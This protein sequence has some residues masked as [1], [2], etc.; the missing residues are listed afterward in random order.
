MKKTLLLFLTAMLLPWLGMAQPTTENNMA[1]KMEAKTYSQY[2]SSKSADRITIPYEATGYVKKDVSIPNPNGGSY[3]NAMMNGSENYSVA[4]WI[5]TQGTINTNNH[6]NGMI[7]D[8][9]TGDHMNFNGNWYISTTNSGNLTLGGHG[10]GNYGA[11]GLLSRSIGTISMNTWNY[12]LVVVNNTEKKFEVYI[13]G[14]R[15]LS[16][17]STNGVFYPWSDGEFHFGG[18]G[19]TC[20]VDG[21]AFFNTALTQEEAERSYQNIFG[22]PEYLVSGYTFDEIADGTKGQFKN[23]VLSTIAVPDVNAWYEIYVGKNFVADGLTDWSSRTEG[24]PVLEEGRNIDRGTVHFDVPTSDMYEHVSGLTFTKIEDDD[25]DG[26][27]LEGEKELTANAKVRIDVECEEGY[28]VSSITIFDEAVTNNGTFLVVKDLD[29]TGIN[30]VVSDNFSELIIENPSEMDYTLTFADSGDPVTDKQHVPEG[31]NLRLTLTDPEN[32][33]INAIKF[34]GDTLELTT[35]VYGTYYAFTMPEDD[36]TLTIDAYQRRKFTVTIDTPEGGTLSVTAAGE[37]VTTGQQITEGTTLDLSY[38]PAQ[39][40]RFISFLVDDKPVG[41]GTTY[42]FEPT[43]DVKIGADVEVSLWCD[44]TYLGDYG[45]IT[46]RTDRYISKLTFYDDAENSISMPLETSN[47][48]NIYNDKTDMVLTTEPGQTLY[49]STTGAGTWM[50]H[51]VYIDWNKD[52]YQSSDRVY[53]SYTGSNVDYAQTAVKVTT[54]PADQAPGIYHVRYMIRWAKDGDTTNGVEV[55]PCVIGEG[56]NG[57]QDNGDVC[58]DFLIEIPSGEF[59]NPRTITVENANPDFG[60]V[61]IVN[62]ETDGNTVETAQAAVEVLATPNPG[63]AF[64]NWSTEDVENLAITPSYTYTEEEAVTLT[65]HFGCTVNHTIGEGGQMTVMCGDA[66]VSDGTV[67]DAESEIVLTVTPETGMEATVKVNGT[68]VKLVGGIY[69][70]SLE[71]NTTIEVTFSLRLNTLTYEVTGQGSVECYNGE[72]GEGGVQLSHGDGLNADLE[73]LYIIFRAE[74]GWE[75]DVQQSQVLV[76]E[77]P[78]DQYNPEELYNPWQEDDGHYEAIFTPPFAGDVH[79]RAIFTQL[80]GIES[81]V[82][83]P[84]DGPVEYYT[85]QGVKVA[86]GKQLEPGIYIARQGKKVTKVLITRK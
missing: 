23:T 75:F 86:V 55:T 28:E 41:E 16:T 15:R 70:F 62:P 13:N 66:Y 4:A 9:G 30:I 7:M 82:I 53:S 32:Y 57:T 27:V 81:T 58:V 68:P 19:I 17:T 65:A 14:E 72:P 50:N 6:T 37:P 60:T 31:A 76:G 47:P 85:L 11:S 26:E 24:T 22:L 10:A 63:Y 77:D 48:R 21:V 78:S 46:R 42:S 64:K 35:N 38:T 59:E 33:V 3:P 73:L 80:D 2:N 1:V 61:A 71:T 83:D 29:Y 12:F 74:E 39:G 44:L 56:G 5:Y 52:G 34:E 84:N 43:N 49:F 36:A 79:V 20:R 54:V 51:Y 67:L 69:T 8:F 45:S 18:Y 25:Q 40:Y